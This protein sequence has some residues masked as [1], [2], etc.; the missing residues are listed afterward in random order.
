MPYAPYWFESF[1]PCFAW[2]VPV[3]ALIGLWVARASHDRRMQQIAERIYF[4][5]MSLVAVATLRTV[6]TE[7]GCWLLHMTSMGIMVLGATFPKTG[8]S[9][10]EYESDVA[11]SDS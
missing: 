3:T 2:I 6:V 5:A 11:W 4:A 1:A 8:S 7:E 9:N 10:S